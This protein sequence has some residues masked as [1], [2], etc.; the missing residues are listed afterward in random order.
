MDKNKIE[1]PKPACT[2]DITTMEVE[3]LEDEVTIS[4]NGY[5]VA[6]WV[7]SEWVEDPECVV[8]AIANA[9]HLAY[10]KP[11]HLIYLNMKHIMSQIEMEQAR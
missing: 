3:I 10:T 6:H 11:S 7:Q 2:L 4:C 1:I 8:P 5:E 9:I